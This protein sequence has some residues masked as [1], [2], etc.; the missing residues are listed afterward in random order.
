MEFD[1]E[2]NP[3]GLFRS[4]AVQDPRSVVRQSRSVRRQSLLLSP[5]S[6][7]ERL[8]TIDGVT[9]TVRDALDPLQILYCRLQITS[10]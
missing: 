9:R 6:P 4:I 2:R 8:E 10:S 1:P 7:R 5:A 3:S